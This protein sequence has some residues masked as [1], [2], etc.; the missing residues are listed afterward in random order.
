[1][2]PE[3]GREFL[4]MYKEFEAEKYKIYPN[5]GFGGHACNQC[6]IIF[7][8]GLS[9]DYRYPE[10]RKKTRELI[11]KYFELGMSLGLAPHYIGLL[12][13]NV[14]MPKLGHT[15]ELLRTIKKTLDPNNIMVPGL[16]VLPESRGVSK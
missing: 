14:I 6:D 2:V 1:M 16:L 3:V 13:Q 9:F 8:A 15:Y 12:R 11:E 4:K 10:T 5:P 7:S